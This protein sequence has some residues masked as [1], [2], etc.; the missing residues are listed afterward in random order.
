MKSAQA[1]LVGQTLV[2]PL[3]GSG[4]AVT[5]GVGFISFVFLR[6]REEPVVPRSCGSGCD[7]DAFM[8]VTPKGALA[9]T[10][11]SNRSLKVWTY[12]YTMADFVLASTRTPK[13]PAGYSPLITETTPLKPKVTGVNFAVSTPQRPMALYGRLYVNSVQQPVP[14]ILF[15]VIAQKALPWGGA[16]AFWARRV[17]GG[18]DTRLDPMSDDERHGWRR[19]NRFACAKEVAGMP[20]IAQVGMPGHQYPMRVLWQHACAGGAQQAGVM[21]DPETGYAAAL[22]SP[23]AASAKSPKLSLCGA[24]K[25]ASTI[26]ASEPWS[27][28]RPSKRS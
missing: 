3:E 8:T 14:S 12:R 27:R 21:F 19:F 18:S 17:S 24:A 7:A 5:F 9:L 22:P 13:T 16:K 11:W 6:N 10:T 28:Q 2:V 23:T 25:S 26:R 20:L 15:D 1:Y 4:G